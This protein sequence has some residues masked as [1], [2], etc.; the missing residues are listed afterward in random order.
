MSDQ[1][2]AIESSLPAGASALPDSLKV[3]FCDFWS[4]FEPSDSWIWKELSRAVRLELDQRNPAVLLY[5]W[6]G[7][8][9]RAYDCTR[10]FISWENRGWGFSQCDFAFTSDRVNSDK[11]FRLPL[12]VCWLEQPFVQPSIDAEAVLAAKRGFASLVVSNGASPTRNRIHA[13][14]NEYST[15]ASGGRYLNNVGGPVDDKAAFISQYKFTIACENSSYAGYVTEKLLHA[16]QANTVPIYWGAPDVALDF[17]PARFINVHD[18]ASDAALMAR[19]VELD[20]DDEAYCE[21]LSQPWFPDGQLPA[22]ADLDAFR[23]HFLRAVDSTS[24]P[25]A[26]RSKLARAPLELADRIRTRQR[27]RQRRT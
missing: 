15:V 3:A 13:R 14:M 23:A 12:W 7:D 2:S 1:S 19:I 10:V 27:Y 5:S 6:Y 20:Q 17:N 25:V 24:T 9:H 8:R 18:F 4:G 11:H 21:V 16:L 22:C 26:Q